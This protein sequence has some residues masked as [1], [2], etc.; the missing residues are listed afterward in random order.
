M[1]VKWVYSLIS[2]TI[3]DR[4]I[5]YM[6]YGINSWK[7]SYQGESIGTLKREIPQLHISVTQ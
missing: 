6:A 7:Y 3:I 4:S 2:A 5:V 1:T